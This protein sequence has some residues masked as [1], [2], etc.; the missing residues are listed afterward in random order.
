MKWGPRALCKNI[1]LDGPNTRFKIMV[2]K[3]I[4]FETQF[5]YIPGIYIKAGI[6]HVI[7]FCTLFGGR[8]ALSRI[9][10]RLGRMRILSSWNACS[11]HNYCQYC[12][13]GFVSL[14]HLRTKFR[15]HRTTSNEMRV[16]VSHKHPRHRFIKVSEADGCFVRKENNSFW[17]SNKHQ[18]G[19]ET[20]SFASLLNFEFLF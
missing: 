17:W 15:N 10:W 6:K 4:F 1:Y 13:S 3:K 5:F 19:T 2:T 7:K 9:Q 8:R 12:D 11:I 14:V 16:S 18:I 20:K